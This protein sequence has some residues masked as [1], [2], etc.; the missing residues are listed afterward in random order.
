MG[1][2]EFG[3]PTPAAPCWRA[4]AVEKA[5]VGDFLAAQP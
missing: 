4:T 3:I 1:A 5:A 2:E